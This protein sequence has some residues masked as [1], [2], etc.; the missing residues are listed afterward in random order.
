[1]SLQ[2]IFPKHINVTVNLCP[3]GE[4]HNLCFAYLCQALTRVGLVFLLN[5][6][7][8]YAAIK[9]PAMYMQISKTNF[10]LEC[11]DRRREFLH[12]ALF[13][14]GMERVCKLALSVGFSCVI[15]V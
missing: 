8:E 6:F 9:A 11:R 4:V 15:E 14:P 2:T 5:V 3:R 12:K 7:R 1:M 13:D 10:N